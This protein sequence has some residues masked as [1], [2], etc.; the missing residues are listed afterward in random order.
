MSTPILPPPPPTA[1]EQQGFILEKGLQA[2]VDLLRA[3]AQEG[4]TLGDT[5]ARL[6]TK[7]SYGRG[8]LD[9]VERLA[10]CECDSSR[11][12]GVI[13]G[14]AHDGNTDYAWV[15]R[16]DVCR[17]FDSD[18]HAAFFAGRALGYEVGFARFDPQYNPRPFLKGLTFE[19]AAA[20][21]NRCSPSP[22]RTL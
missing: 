1:E 14:M 18:E 4:E 11:F 20:L 16:C 10:M 22:T 5:E 2:R 8:W 17:T 21:N 9:D 15:A 3:L 6:I 7:T 19:E 12:P 13:L